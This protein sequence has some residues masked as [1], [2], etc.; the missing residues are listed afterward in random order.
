MTTAIA[1]RVWPIE[2]LT[3]ASAQIAAGDLDV[4]VP[5]DRDD[6][7]GQWPGRSTPWPSACARSSSTSRP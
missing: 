6:E 5:T 7:L 1:S 4:E 3:R 2:A